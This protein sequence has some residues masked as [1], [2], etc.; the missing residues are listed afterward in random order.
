MNL[1]IT[2]TMD[3]KLV[4][5]LNN[6]ADQMIER[7][8]ERAKE[9]RLQKNDLFVLTSK[10]MITSKLKGYL[11]SLHIREPISIKDFV[12]EAQMIIG[13]LVIAIEEPFFV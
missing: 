11:L 3:Y 9:L 6:V 1:K 2:T 10:N 12:K 13:S 7:L 5:K 4:R 8:F